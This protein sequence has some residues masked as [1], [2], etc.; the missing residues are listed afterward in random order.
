MK[1]RNGLLAAIVVLVA[2]ASAPSHAAVE[3]VAGPG[4]YLQTYTTAAVVWARTQPLMFVNADIQ[5]HD[6]VSD[7]T[8]APGSAP[9]CPAGGPRCPLFYAPQV[10]LGGITTVV[11]L[12]DVPTGVH[13]FRC[14]PHSWM[15]AYLVVV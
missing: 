1:V 15:E 5:G 11:G 3:I 7:E 14:T 6:V 13:L 4:S 10:S 9:W 2:G 8:R 12:E